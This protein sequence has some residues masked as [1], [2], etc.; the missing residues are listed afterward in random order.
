M[1]RKQMNVTIFNNIDKKNWKRLRN[2]FK[3]VFDLANKFSNNKT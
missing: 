3:K 1:K 2:F